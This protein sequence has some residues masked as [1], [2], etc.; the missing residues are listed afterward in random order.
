MDRSWSRSNPLGVKDRT[1]PDL[2]TL[3]TGG[4]DNEEGGNDNDQEKGDNENNNNAGITNHDQ[5]YPTLA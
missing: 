2:Q 3:E 4:N 1:G 5:G